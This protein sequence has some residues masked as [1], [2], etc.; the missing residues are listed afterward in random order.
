M[1]AKVALFI[2]TAL[3]ICACA[4]QK[5]SINGIKKLKS[6]KIYVN[7]KPNRKEDI[8]NQLYQKPISSFT[9]FKNLFKKTSDSTNLF[10][11]EK[12]LKSSARLK[13]YFFNNGYFNAS[14]GY[15]IDSTNL[16]KI[17]VVYYVNTGK[18]YEIDGFKATIQSPFLDSLYLKTAANSFVKKGSVYTKSNF[19]SERS[20]IT[21]LFRNKG[22]FDFQPNYVTFAI[23]TLNKKAKASVNLKINDI[24]FR[25][26]DS[27]TSK[28]FKRYKINEVQV[29]TDYS[30]ANEKNKI[31]DSIVFDQIKLYSYAK[32][33]YTPRAITDG[34]FI[35]KGAFF[36]DEN[37]EL[38]NKYLNNLKTFKYPVI[39]YQIDKKDS[40]NTGLLAKLYLTPKEKF[41]IGLDFDVSHS[42][43]PFQYFGIGLKA[44]STIRNIFNGAETLDFGGHFA[45][46]TSKDL[47]V[48]DNNSTKVSE[49]GVDVKLSFPRVL[50]PFSTKKW[51]PNSMIP[52]TSLAFGT[53][54]Q[55]NIGLDKKSFTA[56]LIY[57][58]TPKEKNTSRFDLFNIQYVRNLNAQNYFNIYSTS[59]NALNDIA[60]KPEYPVNASYFDENHNLIIESGTNGF[61]DDVLA[62]SP[63]LTVSTTDYN[64]LKSIA[65]RK[66]RLTENDFI[67]ASSFTFTRSSRKDLKDNEFYSFKSKIETAGSLLSLFSKSN[68]T[69]G[70]NEIFNLAH[71]EYFKTELDFIKYWD[72]KHDNILAIRAFAGIAI[73][74][75]NATSIPFSKSY[76]AGG[77][78]DNRAWLP[79][80]LGPGSNNSIN[81]FNEANMK[82]MFNTEYR[83]KIGGIFGGAIFADAGNIWNVLDQVKDEKSTFTSLKSLQNIALGTGVGLRLDFNFFVF[84]LDF[85]FK[86]YN[87][88]KE[89]NKWFKE[90]NFSKTVLNFGINYPF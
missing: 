69:G 57:T 5:Q 30:E 59:Y 85:G 1:K 74:F 68:A 88:A 7:S 86:T 56:A 84:R 27:L 36:S 20:R 22:A 70:R 89:Y 82:I 72:L 76:S 9:K 15:K 63:I 51:I 45:V 58:W 14:V 38:T 3:F 78:N 8:E 79:Y 77:T 31:K 75:G 40:T 43:I 90:Y 35:K 17:K 48:T 62:T 19:E 66:T 41:H 25:T 21:S 10:E 28:P 67:V 37:T 13:S 44:T 61:I 26:E 49:Y 53:S 12:V 73:P 81:D 6:N 34:I 87:P 2:L 50:V 65:E 18:A 46:G 42:N 23:D 32:L 83:F 39:Q 52:S 55:K 80:S 71:S 64:I 4:T 60:Q 11:T 29:Y 16:K 33:K 24:S 54:T 47:A